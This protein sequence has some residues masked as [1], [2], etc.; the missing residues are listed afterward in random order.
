MFAT[1]APNPKA[2]I[3]QRMPNSDSAFE[4]DVCNWD[5]T[6]MVELS[7]RPVAVVRN[8]SSPS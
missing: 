5:L 6:P 4:P 7:R 1:S 2:D 8:L 3:I